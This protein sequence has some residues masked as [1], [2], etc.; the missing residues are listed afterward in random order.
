MRKTIGV[1]LMFC[2]FINL[3]AIVHYN[4][5]K[6]AFSEES[7][8]SIEKSVIEGAIYFLKA[9]AQAD[10]FLCEYEKSAKQTFNADLAL[11][12]TQVAIEEIKNSLFE[13]EKSLQFA[14]SAGYDEA[15]IQKFKSFNYDG[16][17]LGK[18]LNNDIMFLVKAYFASGNIIGAYQQNIDHIADVLLTLEQVKGML[19]K[20]ELPDVQFAWAL[21]QKLSIAALF[22]S[23]STMTAQDVFAQ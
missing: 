23:Y 5:I 19:N 4:D 18:Q 21:S 11:V 6:P 3:G 20:H 9:K 15:T 7:R 14:K 8:E 2:F 13:Y 22:G 12:Y 16:Y 1:I 17:T 10:L